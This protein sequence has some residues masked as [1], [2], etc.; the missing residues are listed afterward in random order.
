MKVL[1][2]APRNHPNLHHFMKAAS[3]GPSSVVLWG[4]YLTKDGPQSNSQYLVEQIPASREEIE[5]RLHQIRPSIVVSRYYP[6]SVA[7]VLRDY[8]KVQSF[9]WIQYDQK[10]FRPGRSGVLLEACKA[11]IRRARRRPTIRITPTKASG[12]SVLY[13]RFAKFFDYPFDR[14]LVSALRRNPEN[15]K[16]H[17]GRIATVAKIGQRRK[18]TEQLVKALSIT[19]F[20][21]ELVIVGLTQ[22]HNKSLSAAEVSAFTEGIQNLQKRFQGGFEIR[23][24]SDLPHQEC[25]YV[26]S[27]SDIFCLASIRE[28]FAISPMEAM[29]LGVPS[30]ITRRNGAKSYMLNNKTGLITKS[31]R[32]RELSGAIQRMLNDGEL[33]S[34]FSSFSLERIE[35]HHSARSL[36]LALGLDGPKL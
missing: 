21:G 23:F 17:V 5:K 34:R 36:R 4:S 27:T 2:I 1:I 29:A 7:R 24:L 16:Y 28:P 30:I 6:K 20:T 18:N 8:K 10:P 15:S 35:E 12:G 14:D 31:A 25:L 33:R 32:T 3:T 19:G 22:R 26:I 13:S 11:S 9:R